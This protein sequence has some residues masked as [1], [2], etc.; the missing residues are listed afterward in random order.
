MIAHKLGAVSIAFIVCYHHP[1]LTRLN[2]FMNVK[3]ENADVADSPGVLYL[4]KRRR[5]LARCPQ[6]SFNPRFLGEIQNGVVI[7]HAAEKV[8]DDNRLWF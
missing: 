3:T 2:N 7:R 6:L 5:R 1:A 8:R 4:D